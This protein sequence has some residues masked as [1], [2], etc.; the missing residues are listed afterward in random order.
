MPAGTG[1]LFFPSSSEWLR[2][3]SARRLRCLGFRIEGFRVKVFGG[4]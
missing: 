3:A 4:D 2:Y 1:P